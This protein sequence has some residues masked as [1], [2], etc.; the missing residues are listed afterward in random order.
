MNSIFINIFNNSLVASIVI[1]AVL[2]ARLLMKKAPKWMNGILWGIVAIKLVCPFS[3]KSIFSLIPSEKPIPA[4]IE[5][6]TTPAVDT[7]IQRIDSGI[8]QTLVQF[9]PTP[10]ASA[11][12]MQI[13]VGIA[14]VV[15]V[16]GIALML[17]YY[18]VS[19]F[20][21]RQRLRAA[22]M[23]EDN[24][25]ECEA[26]D[27]PFIF[28]VIRPRIYLP[29]QMSEAAFDCVINHERM[30]IKRRDYLWKPVGFLILTVYWFNPLCWVA[31]I[32]LCKDIEFACDERVIKD[33]D[34]E[35][36]TYY[37]QT[38][39]DYGISRK[40]ITSCP[41]AFGEVSVKDRVKSVLSYKK[42][43]F[44]II[45]VSLVAC[46]V[47]AVCFLTGPKK[48]SDI[49]ATIVGSYTNIPVG[50]NPVFYTA[51]LRIEENGS[52]SF[53][54]SL[55][56]SYLG[57]GT[58][59][60]DKD[61]VIFTD[62]GMGDSRTVVFRYENG[63]LYYV[64]DK[65]DSNSMWGL[66]D[67]AEFTLGTMDEIFNSR[68]QDNANRESDG[69]NSDSNTDISDNVQDNQDLYNHLFF[70]D[71]NDNKLEFRVIDSF[72]AY[73][74]STVNS[75][76]IEIKPNDA[77]SLEFTAFNGEEWVRFK[78]GDQIGWVRFKHTDDPWVGSYFL[79]AEGNVFPMRAVVLSTKEIKETGWVETPEQLVNNL[80]H[81]T[82]IDTDM[83]TL[84]K[85][86]VVKGEEISNE[87][88]DVYIKEI[89]RMDYFY[90]L[91]VYSVE[92]RYGDYKNMPN[93]KRLIFALFDRTDT[94]LMAVRYYFGERFEVQTLD[95]DGLPG[96]L[97]T[98]YTVN[99]IGD[100][101]LAEAGL[102]YTSTTFDIYKAYELE[103]GRQYGVIVPAGRG[104][105]YYVDF[106]HVLTLRDNGEASILAA[107]NERFIKE[108]SSRFTISVLEGRTTENGAQIL[109]IEYKGDEAK[110][111]P[112]GVER[113]D[114]TFE[115]LN[116]YDQSYFKYDAANNR[117]YFECSPNLFFRIAKSGS[118]MS[119]Y[120][121]SPYVTAELD[122]GEDGSTSLVGMSWTIDE[123]KVYTLE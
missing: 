27:S 50:K 107:D 87:Y 98:I 44:W 56:S 106:L 20:R 42:P 100:E 62:T 7:G 80:L 68:E 99:D 36:K 35:W 88:Y 9:S 31:Y 120:S 13:I 3:I 49:N 121:Y 34:K 43:A 119:E 60:A 108:I 39:L 23:L 30:H 5:Y 113:N 122:I 33:K 79:D 52:F 97:F 48:E 64:S 41:V 16:A 83:D 53:S 18:A 111:V 75:K 102:L 89:G 90:N 104:T 19:V 32:L 84:L 37:C 112:V 81:S 58:W 76:S 115:S 103:K 28:G 109:D 25:Y 38:L 12:P 77:E 116:W 45:C 95:I 11:N 118:L 73:E 94:Y 123:A 78:Y 71:I 101:E 1:G 105:G 51:S 59:E 69:I 114:L 70:S 10:A 67:G 8:N 61:Y 14:A 21:I 2:I 96:M 117:M 66:T 74:R 65:S 6:M 86:D 82:N 15:W 85:A 55:I 4:D 22:N 46:I 57:Y 17:L 110:H 24:I 54:P 26:I 72:T 92:N 40:M 29:L 47:M 91:H 63:N 93:T